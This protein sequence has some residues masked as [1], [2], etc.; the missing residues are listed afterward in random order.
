MVRGNTVT[1]KQRG[2]IVRIQRESGVKFTGT[3]KYEASKYIEKYK[4]VKEDR[5]NMTDG[6]RDTI[7]RILEVLSSE[8]VSYDWRDATYVGAEAF[9]EMYLEYAKE[10]ECED[11]AYGLGQY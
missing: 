1:D 3:T 5:V 9:I 7:N 10:R 2:W 6:Q 8:G 11:A 4:D